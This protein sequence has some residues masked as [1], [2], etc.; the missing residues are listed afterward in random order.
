MPIRKA[1]GIVAATVNRPHGLPASARTTIS[2]S[3]ARMMTMIANAPISAITPGIAPIS[4]RISSPSDRPSRR[5][6]MNRIMKSCT[7]PART[8]PARIQ[9]VPGR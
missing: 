1:S 7:A 6:E 5:I 2:A 4:M 9:S 3:T 8:T